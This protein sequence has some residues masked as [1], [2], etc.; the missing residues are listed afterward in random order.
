M[1][2]REVIWLRQFADK[3]E[4]KHH[5]SQ[6]E[7][8]ETLAKQK[9]W[10][11]RR[12]LAILCRSISIASKKRLSFGTLTTAGTTKSI[13]RTWSVS[14]ISKENSSNFDGREAL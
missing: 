3:I 7:V 10:Q 13:L 5:V 14:S 12:K 11:V 8:D 6:D 1:I 9:L 2:I 4:R